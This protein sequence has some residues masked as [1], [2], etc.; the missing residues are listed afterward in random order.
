MRHK[1]RKHTESA[2]QHYVYSI[3]NDVRDEVKIFHTPGTN[4]TP[5]P[6]YF[7]KLTGKKRTKR[8]QVQNFNRQL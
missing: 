8:S 1:T 3:K 6:E 4:S 5:A 2:P 7:A